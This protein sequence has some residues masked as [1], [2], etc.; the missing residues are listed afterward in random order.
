MAIARTPIKVSC[1]K[2]S[3]H[4]GTVLPIKGRFGF[5]DG[6]PK[7]LTFIG[8]REQ[9]SAYGLLQLFFLYSSSPLKGR[10]LR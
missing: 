7:D 9:N 4:V 2:G 3:E 5:T 10:G 8:V 1:F 6:L